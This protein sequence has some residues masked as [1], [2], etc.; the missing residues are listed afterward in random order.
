[1]TERQTDEVHVD[2]IRK[3]LTLSPIN[4]PRDDYFCTATSTALLA[5]WSHK[6]GNPGG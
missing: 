1:M 3:G 4:P 5:F 6:D 2:N